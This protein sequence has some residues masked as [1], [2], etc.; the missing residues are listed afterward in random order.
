[1]IENIHTYDVHG[2]KILLKSSNKNLVKSANHQLKFFAKKYHESMNFNI[3]INDYLR[4]PLQDSYSVASDY[5]YYSDEFLDIPDHK[6]CFNISGNVHHYFIDSFVLPVNLIV[7]LALQLKDKTLVHCAAVSYK[8]S[9]IILP[10]LG[11]IGKTTIVTEVMKKG[12]SLYGDDMC[13]IDKASNMYPYPIDF[14]VY[15][16]H[17]KLLGIDRS[18]SSKVKSVFGNFLKLFDAIPI[19]SWFTIRI[20]GKFFP[21]CENISPIDIYGKSKIAK[22]EKIDKMVYLG[23]HFNSKES[24]KEVILSENLVAD[25][26]TSILLSEWRDSLAFLQIYSAFSSNFSYLDMCN[27]IYD[28]VLSVSSVTE[29][30]DISIDSNVNNEDYISILWKSLWQ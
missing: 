30:K 21:E 14:S 27:N 3:V 23:R 20:R 8:S 22:P 11:G 2:I 12:G 17:Y 24:V 6:L 26:I 13:I 4:K 25:R 18:I 15:H 5:Y 1:M 16:Y 29:L 19:I 9:N 28:I 10:A 7:Q